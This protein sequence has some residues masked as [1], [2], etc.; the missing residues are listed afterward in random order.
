MDG[1]VY[2][3]EG[4]SGWHSEQTVKVKMLPTWA[5]DVETP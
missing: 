3:V 5:H 1:R 4:G 2:V